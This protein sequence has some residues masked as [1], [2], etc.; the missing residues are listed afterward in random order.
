MAEIRKLFATLKKRKPVDLDSIV[1]RL[2]AEAFDRIDCL[3]CARCCS[4]LGPRITDRDIARL[5]KAIRCKPSLFTENYLKTDED[6]DYVFQSMP[7]PFLGT[8]NYCSVYDHRPQACV[9]YP[10]TDRRRFVQLLDI[11][12]LNLKTCPAVA[13]ISLRLVNKTHNRTIIFK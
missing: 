11:T 12:L 5:A 9:G 2:H 4:T 13:Y 3:Q 1:A 10:H 7:C 8:D 6:G